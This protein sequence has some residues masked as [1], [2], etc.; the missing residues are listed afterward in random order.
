MLQ[1]LLKQTTQTYKARIERKNRI[2]FLNAQPII[3]DD[4]P[5]MDDAELDA[6]VQ[7]KPVQADGLA[8]IL[9]SFNPIGFFEHHHD[10]KCN[11]AKFH[12]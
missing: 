1:R 8:T 10:Q 2:A 4:L 12:F 7:K 9:G 5:Y 6:M 11:T 3:H